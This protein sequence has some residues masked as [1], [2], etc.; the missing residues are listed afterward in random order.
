MKKEKIPGA[1]TF[2]DHYNLW[3]QENHETKEAWPYERWIN[4]YCFKDFKEVQS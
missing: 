1:L 2:E 4:E 3:L